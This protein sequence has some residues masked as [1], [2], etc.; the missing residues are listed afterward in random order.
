MPEY[1]TE[2]ELKIALDPK[3]TPKQASQLL[4]NRSAYGIAKLR[5]RRGVKTY[6]AAIRRATPKPKP[7]PTPTPSHPWASVFSE[8]DRLLGIYHPSQHLR[9][10]KYRAKVRHE[11][12]NVSSDVHAVCATPKTAKAGSVG[13][14][15]PAL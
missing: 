15:R 14:T 13:S 5:W 3:L 8:D 11:P 7:V 9:I 2:S 12:Q 10:E 6:P 4:L 1:F